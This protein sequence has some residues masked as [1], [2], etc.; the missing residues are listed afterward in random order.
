MSELSKAVVKYDKA[1]KMSVSANEEFEGETLPQ[2]YNRIVRLATRS[3]QHEVS[4]SADDLLKQ[5]K[6]EDIVWYNLVAA[7]DDAYRALACVRH[8][9]AD[10]EKITREQREE[11]KHRIMN[12]I[13][14]DSPN[15]PPAVRNVPPS[16][17]MHEPVTCV[18]C[19]GITAS[20][21]PRCKQRVCQGY[22][23]MG[24]KNCSALH[25][26]KCKETQK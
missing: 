20:M 4:A 10:P 2:I 15:W 1:L 9:I 26:A 13:I 22:G 11:M 23:A 19:D 7:S 24:R 12:A 17:A 16:T 8:R 5:G 21:C 3:F 14:G 25:D 6:F 18:E